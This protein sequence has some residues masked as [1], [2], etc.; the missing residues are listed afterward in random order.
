MLRRLFVGL[1]FMVPGLTFAW[2]PPDFAVNFSTE[3]RSVSVSST[4]TKP[5][6]LFSQEPYIQRTWIINPSSYTIYIATSNVSISTSSNFGIPGV[7]AGN[8]PTIFSP[9]GVN[10]PYTGQLWGVSGDIATPPSIKVFRSK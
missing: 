6:L 8:T 10:S 2:G 4:P 1:I 5:T 3:T 9:D 7:T